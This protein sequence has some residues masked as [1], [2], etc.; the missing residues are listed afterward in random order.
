MQITPLNQQYKIKPNFKGIVYQEIKYL[1]KIRCACCDRKMINPIE[2]GRAFA[3]VSK[4]LSQIMEKGVLLCW[5]QQ[6]EIGKILEDFAKKFPKFS[7]DKIIDDKD[8]RTILKLA[9]VERVK[10]DSE[11]ELERMNPDEKFRYIDKAVLDQF[12][13]IVNRS[14]DPLR[15]AG[16]VMKRM[17]SFKQCLDGEKLATFEQLEIYAQKYPRKT[18][19]EIINMDEIYKFHRTKDLLQRTE[20]REKLDFHFTNIE[21]MI[22]KFDPNSENLIYDLKNIVLDSFEHYRDECS[23]I[24]YAKNL[25]KKALEQYNDNKLVE[26]VWKELEQ[27]PTSFITKD[28]F[29]VYAKNH[30]YSDNRIIASLL[31]PSEVSFEHI[32]P[33]SE[34]GINHATNGI[35]LCRDC[36]QR[37]GSVPYEEFIQYHPKM[38]YNTQKQIQTIADYI[39]K[40]RMDSMYRFWPIKVAQTLNDYT[41]GAINPDVSEYAKKALKQS[42]LKNI[43]NSEELKVIKE[44]RNTKFKE[45]DELIKKLDEI[46]KT[47][48]NLKEEKNNIQEQD[49][50]ENFL[51][52]T[53]DEYL[54]NKKK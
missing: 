10:K 26:K 24:Y 41:N 7:L 19:K 54:D 29:L 45:K 12:G 46:N 1:P 20:K 8:N 2:L 15:G 35:V 38:P 17:A 48:A 50:I 3:K 32:V 6:P 22:K 40:G 47:L 34:N 36:N 4:P 49:K 16:A 9:L 30:N 25:Y 5:Q 37:R 18:L 21:K 44:K 23:R 28:S 43:N 31:I 14:R 13:D 33:R 27:I 53:L 11:K 39:L 52:D 51:Q 42:K